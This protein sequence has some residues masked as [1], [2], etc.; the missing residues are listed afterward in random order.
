M[1]LLLR[2]LPRLLPPLLRLDADLSFLSAYKTDDRAH[3]ELKIKSI[4]ATNARRMGKFYFLDTSF[5]SNAV[6]KKLWTKK[7]SATAAP[8][9]E[10]NMPMSRKIEW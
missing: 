9:T 2:P 4:L 8:T 7:K 10:L 5:V 6:G 3:V 1:P